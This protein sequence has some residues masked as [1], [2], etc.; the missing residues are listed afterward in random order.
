MVDDRFDALASEVLRLV[1]DRLQGGDRVVGLDQE[2]H[3]RIDAERD[4]VAVLVDDAAPVLDQHAGELLGQEALYALVRGV[5]ATQPLQLGQKI[6]AAAPPGRIGIRGAERDQRD[7]AGQADLGPGNPFDLAITLQLV[8]VAERE[9]P[10]E[11]PPI[12][13]SMNAV[14][15]PPK[16]ILLCTAAETLLQ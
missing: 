5:G 9:L 7:A 12:P 15:A 13:R 4:G 10:Q 8:D 2:F 16:A 11:I 3:A 6:L 1:D 14:R